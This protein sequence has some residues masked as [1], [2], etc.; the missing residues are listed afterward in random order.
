MERFLNFLTIFKVLF[1]TFSFLLVSFD[2][3]KKIMTIPV[4]VG[5]DT[6]TTMHTNMHSTFVLALS[7]IFTDVCQYLANFWSF[8][9][10]LNDLSILW[11]LF[12]L[13]LPNF[14]L[15]FTGLTIFNKFMTSLV[16][17]WGLPT[18]LE[19]VGLCRPRS[20]TYLPS[21]WLNL[22]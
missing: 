4:P 12:Y 15:L 13:L 8:D 16:S 9:H 3:L 11:P 1:D 21:R 2:I 17:A 22:T 20:K 18:T 7:V 14:P 6:L 5:G 10:F 19:G